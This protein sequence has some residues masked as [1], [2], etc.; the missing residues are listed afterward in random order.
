MRL[1]LIVVFALIPELAIGQTTKRAPMATQ[2]Q[3]QQRSDRMTV[4]PRALKTPD[5]R[6][7]A[8]TYRLQSI[9]TFPRGRNPSTQP[10][11]GPQR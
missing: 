9:P 2:E 11:L 5:R 3:Q 4:D 1:S 6:N 10:P 8:P 7:L